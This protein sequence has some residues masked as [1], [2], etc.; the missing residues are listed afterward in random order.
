MKD[1]PLSNPISQKIVN[2]FEKLFDACL[3]RN[4]QEVVDMWKQSMIDYRCMHE[5]L[6]SHR[7]FEFEDVCSYQLS[8]DKWLNNYIRLTGRDGMT[9]YIHLHKSGHWAYFLMKYKNVYKCSQQGYENVNGGMK[10]DFLRKSQKGG[11]KRGTSKL[12]PI[13]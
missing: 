10:S 9:K 12:E 11:G 1:I 4:E 3:V 13:M 7:E 2:G 8:A 5:I 6:G